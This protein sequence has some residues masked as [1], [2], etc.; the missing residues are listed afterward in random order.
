[1]VTLRYNIKGSVAISRAITT[2]FY[3]TII[4]FCVFWALGFTYMSLIIASPKKVSFHNT[5][6]PLNN[7]H[8]DTLGAGHLSL[9][10]RLY[11][12]KTN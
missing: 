8:A 6:N 1:M 12:T 4:N 2:M 11:Y 10:E 5:V 7:M 3:M 9:L